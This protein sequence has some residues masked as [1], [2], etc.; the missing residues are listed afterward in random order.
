MTDSQIARQAADR[1]DNAK[2]LER[3]KVK[4]E[5]RVRSLEREANRHKAGAAGHILGMQD[6]SDIQA[7]N[8]QREEAQEAKN[9]AEELAAEVDE[10]NAE[11]KRLEEEADRLNEEAK[12]A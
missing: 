3:E 6:S 4:K 8:Y 11:K 12:K 2:R 1:R 5:Q 7:A 9:E 10:L